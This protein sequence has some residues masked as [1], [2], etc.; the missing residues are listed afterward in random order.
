MGVDDAPYEQRP[1]DSIVDVID[2][3]TARLVATTRLPFR[4]HAGIGGDHLISLRHRIGGG[5]EIEIW[6]VWLRGGRTP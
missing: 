3:S 5:A 2:P 4:I 1:Y 6:K